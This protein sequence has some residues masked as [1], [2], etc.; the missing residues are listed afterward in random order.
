MIAP[1]PEDFNL[2][3]AEHRVERERLRDPLQR[4]VTRFSFQGL[5]AT[6]H[7]AIRRQ[8]IQSYL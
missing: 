5:Q 7:Y 6:E 3:Q 1:A 8:S 2:F 4:F